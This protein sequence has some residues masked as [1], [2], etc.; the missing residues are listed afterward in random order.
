MV[1]R[2]PFRRR[3][4]S[5]EGVTEVI[6]RRLNF[7]SA[8]CNEVLALASVIGRD[9]VWEVL[10]RAAAPLGEDML[11]EA[12][13]EAVAAHILDETTAGRY[14]FAHNLI[15]MTLYDELRI[16]RRRHF[17]RAAGNDADSDRAIDYAVRAGRRAD[18]LAFEDAVQFFQT[19]LDAI[20]QQTEPDGAARCRVRATRSDDVVLE[21]AFVSDK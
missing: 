5:P 8:G 20:E 1:R 7:L 2:T 16:A 6:G 19:A 12:L 18:A 11:L 10:L 3:S 13:D 14:Q 15:R 9:F 21:G 4:A 17:H